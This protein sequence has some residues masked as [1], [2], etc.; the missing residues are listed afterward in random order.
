FPNPGSVSTN[1][2]LTSA[3]AV[4]KELED[5]WNRFGVVPAF[6]AEVI[7]TLLLALVV[8]ATT[9]PR[10]PGAPPTGMAPVFI[11][12]TL[13][14]LISVIAPLTQACFNPARDVGPRIVAYLAGWGETAIPGPRGFLQVYVIAPILGAI[15]GGG[16]YERALRPLFAPVSLS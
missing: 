9:D 4:Q 14:I 16:L 15:I 6:M 10:N 1:A 7:G 13:A 12:L 8:F 3:S 5:G 2:K 11:G